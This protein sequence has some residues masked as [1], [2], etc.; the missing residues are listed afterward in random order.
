MLAEYTVQF[1]VVV[2]K[3][4][5]ESD[6]Q[7]AELAAFRQLGNEQD[8]AIALRLIEEGYEVPEAEEWASTDEVWILARERFEAMP[9]GRLMDTA[10]RIRASERGQKCTS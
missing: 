8:S 9:N 2:E 5:T 3:R 6:S 7:R 1:L 10:W 4:V